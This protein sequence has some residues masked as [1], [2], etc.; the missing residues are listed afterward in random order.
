MT[1][2]GSLKK[3]YSQWAVHYLKPPCSHYKDYIIFVLIKTKQQGCK[4]THSIVRH[5][6]C[7]FSFPPASSS[8]FFSI[9]YL[10]PS[11][12][13]T[14]YPSLPNW[15]EETRVLLLHCIIIGQLLTDVSSSVWRRILCLGSFGKCMG[16]E[17]NAFHEF[18]C[19][20]V[21]A[22]EE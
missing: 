9:I 1:S 15:Y 12:Y 11:P 17:N 21:C 16:T 13:K 20:C 8:P 6:C 3:V 10:F 4:A 2:K 18:L 7:Q 19:V 14:Y 22:F 5:R